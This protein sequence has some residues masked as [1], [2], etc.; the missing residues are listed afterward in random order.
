MILSN[1]SS[2]L[3]GLVDT[4]VL[5]HLDSPVYMGAVAL[6][7]IVISF[8][9]WGC[10]FLRM[11]TTGFTAQAHGEEAPA[12]MNAVL[13]RSI[14]LAECI[15]L[16]MIIG[17]NFYAEAAFYFVEGSDSVKSLAR[18]YF[19]IRVY[20]LPASIA[21]FAII[22]WF[23][24]LHN[25]R[26][27]LLLLILTNVLN[28][29][30]DILFV[31]VLDMNVAGAAYATLIAEY[32]GLFVGLY[33]V[34]RQMGTT[35]ER[36]SREVLFN[37]A[38]WIEMFSVNRD[39]FI[40]TLALEAVFYIMAIEGARLGDNV[41]AANSLLLNFLFLIANGLDGVAQALEAL[42]GKA[43][44]QRNLDGFRRALWSSSLWSLIMSLAYLLLF[45]LVGD[46]II[47]LLTDI[48]SV[49]NTAEEYLIWLI[50]LPLLGVWSYLLDGLFIGATR[51]KEMRDSMLLALLIGFV[52]IWWLTRDFGNHGLWLAFHSFM[53]VRALILGGYFAKLYQAG[54]F[55]RHQAHNPPPP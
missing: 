24:G 22:G 29:I 48:E 40:R 20:G 28:I 42:V 38:A 49:R 12:K 4:A 8:I 2:P 44:G 21:S 33:F 30:L 13:W 15:A 10:N 16:V 34:L 27:P 19:D 32:T 5:G 18:D 14:I 1:I 11:G 23:I 54:A 43:I 26:I 6:G 55:I 50:I 41:L 47:Y 31:V 35:A 3:L 52:P 53:V 51:A 46:G 37:L 39:I 25:T 36:L 9:I 7:S 17:Q 45:W